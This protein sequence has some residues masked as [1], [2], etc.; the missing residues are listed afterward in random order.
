MPFTCISNAF[1]RPFRC[2]SKAFPRSFKSRL[3]PCQRPFEGLPKAIDAHL[4][5]M[6]SDTSFPT[7]CKLQQIVTTNIFPSISSTQSDK[8]P[9][10]FRLHKPNACLLV[11]D[12]FALTDKDTLMFLFFV[13]NT[14]FN[15][16]FYFWLMQSTKTS[17]FGGFW[18]LL[19]SESINDTLI[20]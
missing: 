19:Y 3:K 10:F 2:L 18:F 1:W 17:F 11:V 6:I 15:I 7:K 14:Y 12:L 16:G 5:K 20:F 4:L 9:T 13:K 8:Q